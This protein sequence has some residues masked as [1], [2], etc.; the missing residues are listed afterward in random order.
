[1]HPGPGLVRHEAGAG[2]ITEVQTAGHSVPP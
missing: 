2:S 1:M